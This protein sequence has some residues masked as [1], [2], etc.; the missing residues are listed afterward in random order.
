MFGAPSSVSACPSSSCCTADQSLQNL[1]HQNA[2]PFDPSCHG[3]VQKIVLLVSNSIQLMVGSSPLGNGSIGHAVDPACFLVREENEFG[4][5]SIENVAGRRRSSDRSFPC[6]AGLH[7]DPSVSFAASSKVTQLGADNEHVIL[8]AV[9]LLCKASQGVYLPL[10]SCCRH[11]ICQLRMKS[12][13]SVGWKTH[14]GPPV[15]L[16]L[17]PPS[18]RRFYRLLSPGK[19]FLVH[20]EAFDGWV[21]ACC[22][23]LANEVS[24]PFVVGR[25]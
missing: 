11:S 7:T 15:V 24:R 20:R 22:H 9:D 10:A 14:T 17:G 13:Y 1:G 4:Q 18:T 16:G 21:W 3:S 19:A 5:Q 25:P 6:P 12:S 2:H 23:Q 8:G